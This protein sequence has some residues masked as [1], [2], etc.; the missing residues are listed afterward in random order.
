MV[1]RALYSLSLLWLVHFENSNHPKCA[2]WF[3]C[4]S[5]LVAAETESYRILHTVP[6]ERQGKGKESN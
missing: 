1:I 5:S 3:E 4:F 6:I 2:A